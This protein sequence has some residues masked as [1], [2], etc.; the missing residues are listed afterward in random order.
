MREFHK[1]VVCVVVT[2]S[3][4]W[5]PLFTI[6]RQQL[7]GIWMGKKG[8]VLENFAFILF[9]FLRFISFLFYEWFPDVCVGTMC[10][11][12]LQSP[13]GGAISS[14]SGVTDGCKAPSGCWKLN[15]GFLS[16]QWVLLSTEPSLWH[17][18]FLIMDKWEV[19]E[20]PQKG[21]NILTIAQD[22]SDGAPG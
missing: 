7:W 14:E 3:Y 9:C 17:D 11:H 21:S 18:S 12:H 6:L 5:G 20:P 13:E 1:E 2:H 4:L 15:L 16:E 8:C 10:M 22:S 19:F